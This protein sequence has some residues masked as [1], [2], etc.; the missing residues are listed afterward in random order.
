MPFGVVAIIN[1]SKVDSAFASGNYQEAAMRSESAKKWSI[2]SAVCG[3][4]GI[5]GYVAFLIITAL[6][7]ANNNY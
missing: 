2:W 3:C 4:I 5:V 1:A 6:M 7:A